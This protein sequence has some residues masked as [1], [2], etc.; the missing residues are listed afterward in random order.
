MH[1][2][3]LLFNRAYFG[4]PGPLIQKRCQLAQLIGSSGRVHLDPAVVLI[5]DPTTQPD[6]AGVL[7]D[8]PAKSN[9]LDSTRYK[10]SAGLDLVGFQGRCLFGRAGSESLITALIASR[11]LLAVKGFGIRWKPFSTT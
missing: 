6:V 3:F 7:F 8:E 11:K 10:P 1:G 4:E 9:T 5:A 2:S